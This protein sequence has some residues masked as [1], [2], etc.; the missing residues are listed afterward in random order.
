M[1][2]QKRQHYVPQFYLEFFTSGDG[3]FWVYDKEGG[4]GLPRKQTPIN[5]A[6]ESYFYSFD[7][8]EGEKNNY[9]EEELS[10]IESTARPI[11]AHWQTKGVRPEH[12]EIL[13]IAGF[14]ALM[15]TRVPRNVQAAGEMTE[16]LAIGMLKEEA[17]DEAKMQEYWDQFC[18][19][20]GQP[21]TLTFEEV[22]E[23]A[24]S[25]ETNKNYRIE[26]NHKAALA[27]SMS[28]TML[29]SHLLLEMNWCLCTA[30]SQSFFITSDTPLNVFAPTG[31]G[32]VIFGGGFR[33]PGAEVA[34]P[35]SPDVCLLLNRSHTQGRRRVKKNTV[36]EINRRTAFMAERFIISPLKTKQVG[37]LVHKAAKTREM[38]KIDQEDVIKRYS[39]LKDRKGKVNPPRTSEIPRLRVSSSS[40]MHQSRPELRKPRQFGRTRSI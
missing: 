21:E 11:L 33:L 26:F 39:S 15:H 12:S 9:I 17:K 18:E 1:S 7:T 27:Q 6:V 34:F 25:P 13:Q 16:A 28:Q 35:L 2:N 36:S 30:P 10:K 14:L 24:H 5:T 32:T 3:T 29:I 22:L 38:P 19:I 23:F 31:E 37:E 20:H 40:P 8:P 4:G